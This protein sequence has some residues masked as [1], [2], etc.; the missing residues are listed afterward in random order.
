MTTKWIDNG[1]RIFDEGGIYR[2]QVDSNLVSWT[3]KVEQLTR[4]EA[5]AYLPKE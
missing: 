1:V 2:F 4:Q 3:L 5:E